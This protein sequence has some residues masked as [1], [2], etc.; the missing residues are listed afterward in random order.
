MITTTR[1]STLTGWRI[2]LALFCLLTLTTSAAAECGWVLWLE[3]RFAAIPAE[4]AWRVLQGATT[5]DSCQ[6]GLYARVRD[7][8]TDQATGNDQMLTEVR[9]PVITKLRGPDG[10]GASEV[11]RY[12]C[13][14]DPVDPRGAKGR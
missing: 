11:L 6:T 13:L 7:D 9:G 5:Y 4:S 12:V 14:P 3:E 10:R 8:D 1:T 2:L